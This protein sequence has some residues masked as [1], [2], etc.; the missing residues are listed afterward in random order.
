MSSDIY[1]THATHIKKTDKITF[2]QK[3]FLSHFNLAKLKTINES[4]Q[5]IN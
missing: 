5:L 1:S 4:F 3:F 2:H